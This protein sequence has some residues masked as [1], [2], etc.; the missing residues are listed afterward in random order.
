MCQIQTNCGCEFTNIVVDHGDNICIIIWS[1]EVVEYEQVHY[2][3]DGNIDYEGETFSQYL[4]QS[5]LCHR[6]LI[7]DIVYLHFLLDL[8]VELVV[9]DFAFLTQ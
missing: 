6:I 3:P 5:E 8:M 9:T 2:N 1:I 4:F 7:Y